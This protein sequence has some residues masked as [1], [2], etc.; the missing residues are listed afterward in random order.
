MPRLRVYPDSSGKY[1]RGK[2]DSYVLIPI[3]VGLKNCPIINV[4]PSL[5]IQ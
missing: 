1:W 5:A 2:V 4:L 3:L